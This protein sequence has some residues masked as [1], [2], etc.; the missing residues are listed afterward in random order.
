M[1]LTAHAELTSIAMELEMVE[2]GMAQT[3]EGKAETNAEVVNASR[4]SERE[5]ARGRDRDEEDQRTWRVEQG[6]E[7]REGPLLST[8][9]KVRREL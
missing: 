5:G 2:H 6:G 9:G 1:Y 3:V 8:D 7:G 4:A